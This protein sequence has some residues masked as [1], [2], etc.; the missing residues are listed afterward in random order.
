MH[1]LACLFHTSYFELA[2]LRMKRGGIDEITIGH[3]F[4]TLLVWSVPLPPECQHWCLHIPFTL[5]QTFHLWS[6]KEPPENILR[7]AWNFL[8]TCPRG[9]SPVWHWVSGRHFVL[10]GT[11]SFF[12]AFWVGSSRMMVHT[13]STQLIHLNKK[14][15]PLQGWWEEVDSS[16]GLMSVWSTGSSWGRKGCLQQS[17]V[18]LPMVPSPTSLSPFSSLCRHQL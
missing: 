10:Y 15:P 18:P 8:L 17:C 3:I 6:S 5:H 9:V 7:K 1:R 12:L 16:G 11:T 13:L 4:L 14:E 2:I